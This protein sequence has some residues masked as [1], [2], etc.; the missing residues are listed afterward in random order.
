MLVRIQGDGEKERRVLMTRA[1]KI[2]RSIISK[3]ESGSV[4]AVDLIADRT[5]G[6]VKDVFELRSKREEIERLMAKDPA[7]LA[8]R[9]EV[10]TK[11]LRQAG[12]QRPG[13]RGADRS[14]PRRGGA[15]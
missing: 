12:D 15:S 8:Q 10:L 1:E 4:A 3:A 5:D 14:H 2:A 6:K 13:P 7:E 11:K 9:L